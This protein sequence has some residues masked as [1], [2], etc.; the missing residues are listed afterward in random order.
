MIDVLITRK[1]K[2][3]IQINHLLFLI[4]YNHKNIII[5]IILSV[6]KIYQLDSSH[7]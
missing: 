2:F 7:Y 4:N 6:K 3:N 1:F 5:I